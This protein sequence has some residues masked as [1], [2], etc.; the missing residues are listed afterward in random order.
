VIY[1]EDGNTLENDAKGARLS[2]VLGD[3]L[4]GQDQYN[5]MDFRDRFDYGY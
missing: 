3:V 4:A 2:N 1:V 5:G